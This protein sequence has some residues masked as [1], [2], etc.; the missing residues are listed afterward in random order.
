MKTIG[1]INQETWKD[2]IGYEGAY[3]VSNLGNVKSVDRY[4]NHMYGTIKRKSKLIKPVEVKGYK[5]VRLSLNNK[6]RAF[7]LHRIVADAFVSGKSLENKWVNHID[8]NKLNNTPAN[9]EWCTHSHNLKHAF[10]TGLKTNTKGENNPNSKLNWESINN[11]RN[12][13][14]TAKELG[15]LYNVNSCHIRSIKNNKSWTI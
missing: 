14:I 2:V 8:G 3:Q 11:I 9:L 1:E 5:Q 4:V 13:T 12:S 7:L 10:R 6:S 15:L